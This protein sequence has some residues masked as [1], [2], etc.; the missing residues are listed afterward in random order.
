MMKKRTITDL[1]KLLDNYSE[2]FLN[3]DEVCLILFSDGS[4]RIV[5]ISETTDL[6]EFDNIDELFKKL[7]Y[8]KYTKS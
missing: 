1:L 6:F 4:G 8:E 7:N 5:Y 3:P 2:N